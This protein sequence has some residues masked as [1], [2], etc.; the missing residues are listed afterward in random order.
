MEDIISRVLREFKYDLL[1]IILTGKIEESGNQVANRTHGS[2]ISETGAT[3]QILPLYLDM[4]KRTHYCIVDMYAY[5][6]L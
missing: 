3:Y 2:T 1:K 6:L 5:T 4:Q